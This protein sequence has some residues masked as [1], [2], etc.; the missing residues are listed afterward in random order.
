MPVE[1]RP[2]ARGGETLSQSELAK[3]NASTARRHAAWVQRHD[4]RHMQSD[5]NWK[6]AIYCGVDANV[7]DADCTPQV[8][9]AE[10]VAM[11]WEY[12]ADP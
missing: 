2:G 1:Q 10:V 7:H 6:V 4:D 8:L 3:H 5:Q 12:G 9:A 11:V